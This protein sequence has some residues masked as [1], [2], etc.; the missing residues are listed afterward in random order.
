[1]TTKEDLKNLIEKTSPISRFLL[2]TGVAVLIWIFSSKGIQD[3]VVYGA[4]IFALIKAKRGAAAWK[5]PAGIAFIVALAYL[6]LTIPFSTSPYYSM[7]DFIKF[8]EVIAGAFAIP[9][10]FNTRAK[11]KS[12]LFYS[13]TAIAITMAYDLARLHYHLGAE[14]LHGA[15]AFEPFILNH[16]P[17]QRRSSC[18]L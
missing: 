15:H 12:A 11:I 18:V 3:A 16:S 8:F 6:I 9:V 5:Q 7:R 14:I 2:W 17:T 10:I 4:F 1:M 13:A